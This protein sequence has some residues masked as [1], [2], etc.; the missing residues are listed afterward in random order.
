M[1]SRL[2]PR[3]TLRLTSLLSGLAILACYAAI[4]R[5]SAVATGVLYIVKEAY[6]VLIIEQY[7][8]FLNSTLG[9]EKARRLNG[10]ICG[11]ASLGA[12]A[13]GYLVGELSEPLG[14]ASMLLFAGAAVIPAAVLSDLAYARAGEPA[15]EGEGSQN[16]RAG[17]PVLL[18]TRTPVSPKAPVPPSALGLGL[19][20]AQ[21][22]L[23]FLLLTVVSTQ[24]LS[25]ALDL[26]FQGQLQDSYPRVNEQNA[27]SGKF[28]MWLSVSAA[29]GQFVLAPLLLSIFSL[30]SI[31]VLLPLLN[32][33]ACVYLLCAPSLLSAGAAYLIFKTLDYSLF[34]A[35]K[36]ILYIPCSFDVRYRAKEVIDVLGYRVSK[37]GTSLIFALLDLRGIAVSV[38]SYA[39]LALLG[40]GAWLAFVLPITRTKA[41]AGSPD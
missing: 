32:A 16:G 41:A 18:S 27:W 13:G 25:T 23:I 20:R 10:P 34:R 19:F 28:Y 40:A 21:P 38:S 1:L 17:T 24:V 5:G 29:L 36:E 12:I 30:R 2:G 15:E 4:S 14:A 31:H 11:I 39:L 6:V 3:R 26:A 9:T 22:M 37:G 35:A 8:S 33:A 7:W